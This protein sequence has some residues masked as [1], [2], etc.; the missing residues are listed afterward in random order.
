MR[1]LLTIL[2]FASTLSAQVG[3]KV[4]IGGKAAIGGGLGIQLPSLAQTTW[5]CGQFN[6]NPSCTATSGSNATAGNVLVSYVF[7]AVGIV[8]INTPTGCAGTWTLVHLDATTNQSFYI[9]TV[10]ST[11]SCAVT[12]SATASSDGGTN[13]QVYELAN[14]STTVDQSNYAAGAGCATCTGPSITTTVANDIVL[15]FNLSS[16]NPGLT[17]NAPFTIDY[18]NSPSPN[19][20]LIFTAH[21]ILATTGAINVSWSQTNPSGG[22]YAIIAIEP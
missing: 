15:V 18:D 21:T 12:E 1:T 13:L 9:G 20:N 5:A 19:G 7:G 11:G 6:T 10:A 4:A 3:G 16:G 14:A 2:L 22:P 8:T 17:V